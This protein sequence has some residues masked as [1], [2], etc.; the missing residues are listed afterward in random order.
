MSK[1]LLACLGCSREFPAEAI[2]C[3]T[4]SPALMPESA[5]PKEAHVILALESVAK[6]C[7]LACPVNDEPITL[8]LVEPDAQGRNRIVTKDNTLEHRKAV[9][10]RRGLA[11]A[12]ARG[13]KLPVKVPRSESHEPKEA[14]V[15][16]GDNE[17]IGHRVKLAL[18]ANKAK[19]A[20]ERA[21]LVKAIAVA[22][23]ANPADAVPLSKKHGPAIVADALASLGVSDDLEKEGGTS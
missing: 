6:A 10:G 7:G 20:K 23:E 4:C 1:V 12:Y 22:I 2:N 11:D 17:A 13:M 8:T 19:K 5:M 9:N 14:H 21:E 18:E 3:P 16:L 15:I